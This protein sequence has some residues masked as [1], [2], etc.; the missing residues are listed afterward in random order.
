MSPLGTYTYR[1]A[2]INADG[3][4]SDF[5]NSVTIALPDFPA[6]PTPVS[7]A[8]L[9]TKGNDAKRI[10]VT[11]TS[12]TSIV[13]GYTVQWSTDSTF[14]TLVGTGTVDQNTTSFTTPKN[15]TL[16]RGTTYYFR[17]RSN[18]DVNGSSLWA[19]YVA[20]ALP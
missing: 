7:I 12:S 11:W 6:A 15:A 14:A 2:A 1:V 10:T 5:S 3:W 19:Y 20:Y 18:S 13:N 8:A 16:T 4:L 17:I 9:G